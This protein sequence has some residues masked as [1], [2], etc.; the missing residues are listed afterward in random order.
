[1]H[2]NGEQTDSA[3]TPEAPPAGVLRL[4]FY[5]QERAGHVTK[6]IRST[7]EQ[8]PD[9][10][11]TW[12]QRGALVGGFVVALGGGA[13]LRGATGPDLSAQVSRHEA[14][15]IRHSAAIDTLR[16]E[17][18]RDRAYIYTELEFMSCERKAAN[19]MDGKTLEQC[20]DDYRLNV[21]R[22]GR[23]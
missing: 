1:M 6:T 17:V 5:P 12:A 10:V 7:W 8:L 20:I 11:R 19:G 18:A 15:I 13:A 4:S 2:G 9:Q 14:T 21:R 3:H 23:E 16:T 22:R